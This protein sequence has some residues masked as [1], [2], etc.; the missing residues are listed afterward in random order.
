MMENEEIDI[1]ALKKDSD[2]LENLQRLETEMKAENS[3]AKGYQVLDAKLV[4]EA[5]EDDINE[6]FTFIVNSAF[7][8]LSD[9][10]TEPRKFDMAEPEDWATVR[11]IYEHAIQR[12]SEN[13]K[14]G[15]KEIFLVLHHM[16]VVDELKD[17][18]MIHA[19]AVMAGHSFEEFVENLADVDGA[20]PE[21]PMAFFITTFTQ[22]NDILL[23]M[24]AKYVKDGKEELRVLEANE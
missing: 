21:D 6:V 20:D 19:C 3:I 4:I 9:Y 12:Y 11:A 7:D 23:T 24:F 15:A 13:D 2:F 1:E 16:V 5:D 17:A 22:P 14:K 18:M 10:L 8:K